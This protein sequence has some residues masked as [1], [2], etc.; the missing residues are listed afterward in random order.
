VC[1][2]LL[3]KELHDAVL[4]HL[5]LKEKGMTQQHESF[6][7]KHAHQSLLREL[8]LGLYGCFVGLVIGYLMWRHYPAQTL[9]QFAPSAA[10]VVGSDLRSSLPLLRDE[11]SRKLAEQSRPRPYADFVMAVFSGDGAAAVARRD[12]MRDIYAAYNGSVSISAPDGNHTYSIQVCKQ[13]IVQS[14]HD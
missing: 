10:A 4:C 11:H 9:A 13:R 8:T 14:R 12:T 6:E 1:D 2:R 3:F 7:K 5:V